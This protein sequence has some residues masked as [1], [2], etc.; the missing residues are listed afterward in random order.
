MLSESRILIVDP[1]A[2]NRDVLSTMFERHGAQTLQTARIRHACRLAERLRPDVILLDG[3]DM[4][5]PRGEAF[6]DLDR[7]A[8]RSST[9]IVVLGS[10]KRRPRALA[11]GHFVPKPYHYA[12]LIRRIEVLLGNRA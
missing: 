6:E 2:D 1:S 3:D 12:A 4:E 9:P 10:L 11:T 5:H 7:L 8:F